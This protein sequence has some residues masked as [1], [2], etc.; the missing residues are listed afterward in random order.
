M[1]LGH[2]AYSTWRDC[3]TEIRN[4]FYISFG[5]SSTRVWTH[6]V[7]APTGTKMLTETMDVLSLAPYVADTTSYTICVIVQDGVDLIA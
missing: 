6:V 2:K 3:P 7:V 1:F 5:T 4:H